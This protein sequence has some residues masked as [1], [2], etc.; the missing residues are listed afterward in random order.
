MREVG[1]I[2]HH[3]HYCDSNY[4]KSFYNFVSHKMGI[5]QANEA[6]STQ[7]IYLSFCNAHFYSR[8]G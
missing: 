6:I 2:C 4:I 3:F 7:I 5:D 8:V 1:S